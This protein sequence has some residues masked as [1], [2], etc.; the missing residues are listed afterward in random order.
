MMIHMIDNA[1]RRLLAVLLVHLLL[2]QFLIAGQDVGVRVSVFA[3]NGAQNI[4]KEIPPEPL[5]VRVVDRDNRPIHGATVVFTAPSEGPGGDFPSGSKFITLTD[6]G[7]RALGVL[8]RANSVEGSYQI[9][10]RA[11]YLGE[12]ATASIRQSNVL[13]KKSNGRTFLILAVAGAAAAGTAIGAARRGD[14]GGNNPAT[15]PRPA[16]TIT[17]GG[18]SVGGP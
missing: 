6:E 12:E 13:G 14:T 9:Q 18:S 11:E 16:T 5:V 17:F 3:G 4:V 1:S 15:P 2:C 7:G 10:V 8:Y